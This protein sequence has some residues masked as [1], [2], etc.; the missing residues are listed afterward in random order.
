[1]L[2]DSPIYKTAVPSLQSPSKTVLR[3]EK[4]LVAIHCDNLVLDNKLA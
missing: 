2:S 3:V 1:M 4:S